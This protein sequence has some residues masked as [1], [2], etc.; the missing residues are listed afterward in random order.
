MDGKEKMK[1]PVGNGNFALI[2]DEDYDKV[3]D[4]NWYKSTLGYAVAFD[5]KKYVWMHRL[6]NSTPIGMETDHINRSKLDNRKSNL[7]TCTHG[8][9]HLNKPKKLGTSSRFVGVSLYRPRMTWRTTVKKD[10]KQRTVGYFK[11]ELEAALAYDKVA[12]KL[13]GEFAQCNIQKH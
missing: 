11:N 6:I 4:F 13:H 8:Q 1:H 3:K 2:D 5:G 9:N 7:R 10:G 12:S